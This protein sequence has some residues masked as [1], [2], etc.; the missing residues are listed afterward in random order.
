MDCGGGPTEL[1][2]NETNEYGKRRVSITGF[3]SVSG[4]AE[5]CGVLIG[6]QLVFV[7]GLPVGAGC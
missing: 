4:M 7:N 1:V 5:R 3:T 2:F 6:D